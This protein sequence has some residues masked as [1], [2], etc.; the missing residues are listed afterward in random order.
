[1][2]N[3]YEAPQSEVPAANNENRRWRL[4]IWLFALA[5]PPVVICTQVAARRLSLPAV[6]VWA[7]LPAE[8]YLVIS[9]LPVLVGCAACI[10]AAVRYR[11]SKRVRVLRAAASIVLLLAFGNVLRMALRLAFPSVF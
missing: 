1:M 2:T 7:G 9:G 8:L 6:L 5:W 10:V 3:P 4:N 11:A